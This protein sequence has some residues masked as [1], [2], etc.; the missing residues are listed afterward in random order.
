MWRLTVS[1]DKTVAPPTGSFRAAFSPS[2][3]VKSK[4]GSYL[5]T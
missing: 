2:P 5:L 1:R 3:G 4:E